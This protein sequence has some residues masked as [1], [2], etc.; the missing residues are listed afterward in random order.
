MSFLNPKSILTVESLGRGSTCSYRARQVII[1]YGTS[2][3]SQMSTIS[4]YSEMSLRMELPK[5]K[6]YNSQFPRY[7]DSANL[8]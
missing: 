7:L 4:L 6:P 3:Y 8:R 2:N 5:T 1:N